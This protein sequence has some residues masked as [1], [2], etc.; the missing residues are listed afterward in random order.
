MEVLTMTTTTILAIFPL[1][2]QALLI[3]H[4]PIEQQLKMH[5]SSRVASKP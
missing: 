2:C 5:S 1:L 3:A 4:S